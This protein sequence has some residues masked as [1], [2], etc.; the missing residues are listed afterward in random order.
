MI[1]LQNGYKPSGFDNNNTSD[2]TSGGGPS[3]FASL[4]HV[5]LGDLRMT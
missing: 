2:W 4:A 1:C 5:A 3:V